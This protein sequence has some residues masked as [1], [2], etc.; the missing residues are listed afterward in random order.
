M[1]LG[2]SLFFSSC[3]DTRGKDTPYRRAAKATTETP[4][5]FCLPDG[6][7]GFVSSAN[8]FYVFPDKSNYQ[9]IDN[10]EGY[11][12]YSAVGGGCV[13]KPIRELWAVLQNE[14]GLKWTDALSDGIRSVPSADAAFV[15]ET[16]Y[17]AGPSFNKRMVDWI[18]EWHHFLDRGTMD[19]PEY[20]KIDFQKT[21]G[22][23]YIVAFRGT[24]HLQ[25]FADHV[26]GYMMDMQETGGKQINQEN[27][28]NAVTDIYQ[29]LLNESPN[30]K[31]LES[32]DE[33]F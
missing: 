27:A 11:D 1:L 24:V 17:R 33:E 30:W 8:R 9:I 23:E 22:T 12:V 26:T 29:N 4:A 21:I 6:K 18:V 5:S 19:Q 13:G 20:L 32:E 2:A 25:R 15:F 3:G 28:H 7:G 31:Y 10:R 14:S 16:Q